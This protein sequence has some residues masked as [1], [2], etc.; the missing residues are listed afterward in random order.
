MAEHWT[1]DELM[2]AV[3][4]R[5]IRS[6]DLLLEGIGTYLPTCGYELAR[7][8]HA[9]GVWTFSSV[10]AV[11]R[12][13]PVVLALEGYEAAVMA[14]GVRRT[15]YGEM[16][17]RYLPAYLL[18]TRRTMKE[19]GRPA[20]VDGRGNTNNVVIGDYHRPTLRL[21]GA[22]GIPDGTSLLREIN[23]YAPRHSPRTLVP[24][25]DFVSGLG[26]SRPDGPEGDARHGRPRRLVTDL[27]VIGFSPDGA[28]IESVH[29]HTSEETVREATGFV[30]SDRRPEQTEP[31]SREE[32]ELMRK[33]IDPQGLRRLELLGARDRRDMLRRALAGETVPPV[34]A[35]AGR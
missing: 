25:C 15:D 31:P 27:A 7:H 28:Y 22:V 34:A 17:L 11:F 8:T 21:P 33:V 23:L 30:L 9:P 5:T 32:V 18:K 14:A 29:P 13:K 26:W 10:G 35:E 6:D 12:T 16:A 3:I 1:V 4:A 20:Q 24:C 19:F 2:C